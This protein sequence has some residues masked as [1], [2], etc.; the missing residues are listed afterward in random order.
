VARHRTGRQHRARDKV[1]VV[2]T[3]VSLSGALVLGHA[4]NTTVMDAMVTLTNTVIG[5]GGRSDTL[6]ERVQQKL[7]ATVQ[8]TGYGYEAVHYPASLDL[9][10]SRDIGVPVMQLALAA[11]SSEEHLIV[12]GYSE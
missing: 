1:L 9:A 12:A 7:R 3:A 6:S 8:P 5:A 11:H 2:V 10:G 4:T